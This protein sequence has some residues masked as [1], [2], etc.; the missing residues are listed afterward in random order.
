MEVLFQHVCH[1]ILLYSRNIL[2]GASGK[3]SNDTVQGT[4]S[5]DAGCGVYNF[6]VWNMILNPVGS[7]TTTIGGTTTLPTG[8]RTT[9]TSVSIGSTTGSSTSASSPSISSTSTS[10]AVIATESS[11]S[12]LGKPNVGNITFSNS[13]L[14][15]YGVSSTSTSSPSMTIGVSWTT[16]STSSTTSVATKKPSA[17]LVNGAGVRKGSVYSLIA[18]AAVFGVF[19]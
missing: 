12:L 15:S 14:S 18:V 8:T 5:I 9:T 2:T 4:G 17:V 10:G 11:I 19:L 6:T 7:A 16:G 3:L 1:Q 13:T